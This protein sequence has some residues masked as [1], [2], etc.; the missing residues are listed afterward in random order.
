MKLNNVYPVIFQAICLVLAL[1]YFVNMKISISFYSD[2]VSL[3]N[4]YL[5]LV[6]TTST[7]KYLLYYMIKL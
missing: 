7:V 1:H 2:S 5:Y 6:I 3:N 4:L